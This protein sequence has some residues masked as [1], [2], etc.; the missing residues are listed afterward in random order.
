MLKSVNTPMQINNSVTCWTMMM[1]DFSRC[2]SKDFFNLL[3]VTKLTINE[4]DVAVRTCKKIEYGPSKLYEN[5]RRTWRSHQKHHHKLQREYYWF[6]YVWPVWRA[7][8]NFESSKPLISMCMTKSW[9]RIRWG[10][11]NG[12]NFKNISWWMAIRWLIREQVRCWILRLIPHTGKI[13][14]KPIFIV[15]IDHKITCRRGEKLHILNGIYT[16]DTWIIYNFS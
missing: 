5:K 13:N 2:R 9:R 7:Y 14:F 15:F 8:L 6:R 12:R 16:L 4:P 11:S 10:N 3:G 1:M